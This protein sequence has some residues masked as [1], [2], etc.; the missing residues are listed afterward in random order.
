GWFWYVGTLV[1]VIGIVQSGEQ[2]HGDH[3]TY[4]PLVG[5]FIIVVWVATELVDKWPARRAA[6]ALV[7]IATLA[8]LSAATR[9][10]LSYWKNS[11]TLWQ[12]ALAINDETRSAT[13]TSAWRWL[14][15][16]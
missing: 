12:H 15:S 11:V 7:S 3:F 4:V 10:Q 8:G 2:S 13:T 16:A 6:L 14:I 5:L 9:T 1:P